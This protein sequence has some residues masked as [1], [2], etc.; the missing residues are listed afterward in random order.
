VSHA[1]TLLR[2][3]LDQ[4]G[5]GA[6]TGY[7]LVLDGEG[8]E[9]LPATMPTR[10]SSYA[11]HRTS[12]E[13]GLRHL[14]WKARR[15]PVIAVLPGELAKRLP[16]DILRRAQNQRVHALSPNDV[17]DVVLGVRV[18][19]AD[20][21]Y[22]QELALE[23][24]EQLGP[25]LSRQ[26]LPTVVDRRLLTE[27]LVDVSVGEKVRTASAAELLASWVREPPTWSVNVRRLVSEALPSLHA[28]EGRLLAWMLG[29]PDRPRLLIIHGAVLSV[30]AEEVPRP[31]WGPLWQAAAEPPIE[32]DR[33]VVRRTACSLAV[34]ALAILGD[35]A[36]PLLAQADRIGRETLTPKVL[37]TSRILPLAFAD[38]CATLAKQASEGKAIPATDMAWLSAHRAASMHGEDLAVL[39]SIARLSRYLDQ[40]VASKDDVLDQVIEYQRS[41]AFADLAVLH[42]RRALAGCGRYHAEAAKVI[43]AI[44]ARRDADNE[45]FARTLA[46]SYEAALHRESVTPLHRAWKRVVAPLWQNDPGARLLIVVLDGCTYALSL[47]I[48][49][50]LSQDGSLPMGIAPAKDGRVAGLPALAPLP[51]VTSHA[52]GA[53]FLGEIPQDPLVAETVFRDQQEAKTD[54]AR[55]AQNAALGD[56]TRRLFLKGDLAD[57]GQALLEAIAD[58]S[59]AVVGAVFNAVDDQIGSANTGAMIRISPEDIVAFKPSLHAAI[60]AG[61]RVLLT[62]DHGHSAF[63]D[64]SLRVGQGPTSRFV[65]LAANDP[66]PDGFIEIDLKGL[67]GPPARRAFAWRSGVYL[68]GAQVG[69]HGGCGLEEMVVPLAWIEQDG[70]QADEPDWWFGGGALPV[71][72][73]LARPVVPPIVTPSRRDRAILAGQYDLFHPASRADRLPL[74]PELLKKLSE[75]QKSVLVLLKEN[76]SA[77][78]SELAERLRKSPGRLNGLM[79]TL[80]RTL[81]AEGV[82]LYTD[83]VLPTG[84]TLYRYT[85]GVE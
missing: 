19:G 25:A 79:R 55:F 37:E 47:E 13:V 4:A 75:D 10:S 48:I 78:A 9:D 59:V 57:G 70:L 41:G 65:V 77:R 85:E 50:R 82:V 1:P 2:R 52:R 31:A 21:P 27:L 63:I 12:T 54:K 44:R 56:R 49:Y 74:P 29:A 15:A 76:G 38:R 42:L 28:D 58:E 17:L 20:T 14:L 81:H 46:A 69:F 60:R 23:Y 30:D 61:R 66:V 35:V 64:K 8:L 5:G 73:E 24:I 22:L 3:V 67:G 43:V 18:I 83:E 7:V 68:G 40:P 39:D 16:P 33:R 36:A 84:E 80:R 45:R 72:R 62:A 6:E 34:D 11:V 53:L 51:T 32:T 71:E 26:T